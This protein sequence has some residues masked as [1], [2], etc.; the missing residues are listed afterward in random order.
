MLTLILFLLLIPTLTIAITLGVWYSFNRENQKAI[1]IKGVLIDIASDT[2]QLIKDVK[3]LSALL[4][5]VAQ[6]LLSPAAIDVESQDVK[7]E[8]KIE[9]G[10]E[11]PMKIDK[12]KEVEDIRLIKGLDKNI[13]VKI[14]EIEETL[15]TDPKVLNVE[16][17]VFE[18]PNSK[19]A[20]EVAKEDLNGT[21][22]DVIDEVE[23]FTELIQKEENL[24]RLK[25]AMQEW[26]GKGNERLALACAVAIEELK[27]KQNG[28]QELINLWSEEELQMEEDIA[29]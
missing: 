16:E 10:E 5:E 20:G 19:V 24:T 27:I 11:E 1:E 13:K 25:A 4:S 9:G 26:K 21:R 17:E 2:S 6:P 14:E 28:R 8:I 12:T 18:E 15:T 3:G 7:D 29:S 22:E 23:I